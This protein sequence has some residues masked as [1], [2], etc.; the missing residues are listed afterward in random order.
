MAIMEI[1]KMEVKNTST[2]IFKQLYVA[3]HDFLYEEGFASGVDDKFPEK[4]YWESRAQKGGKEYWVWWRFCKPQP[5]GMA[6]FL[7]DIDFHGVGVRDVEIMYQ[8]KKIKANKG[9][10]EVIIRGKLELDPGDKFKN[11]NIGWLRDIFVN[12]FWR[13]ERDALRVDLVK[14]MRKI[15]AFAADFLNKPVAKLMP[16]P[17]YPRMGYDR[18]NF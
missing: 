3:L 4:F 17:F 10:L 2:F 13:K 14:D 11:S 12:R 1:A 7:I 5:N 8:G 16:E 9:K 15:R 18:E 6:N